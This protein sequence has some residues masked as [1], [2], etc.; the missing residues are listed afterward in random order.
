M[1]SSL[2]ENRVRIFSGNRISIP[3]SVREKLGLGPGDSVAFDLVDGNIYVSRA[4]HAISNNSSTRK[5]T[6]S[7]AKTEASA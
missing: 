1:N 7:S 4:E 2:A 5:S 6:I 3:K